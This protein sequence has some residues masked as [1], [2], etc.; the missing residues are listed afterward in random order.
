M[1]SLLR[2]AAAAAILGLV[3][4]GAGA[5]QDA[6]PPAV[7]VETLEPQTVTLTSVLPGRV[8]ASAEAEV[9]PQV[10]GIVT[11]RLFTEGGT[12][13][14]GDVLYRIDPVSYDAAVAQARAA[15]A[16]AEA[17]LRVAE[18]EAERVQTLSER[19]ISS[20]ANEE[21]A[22]STRDAAAAGLEAARAQLQ[23][24]EIELDRTEVRARLSG[25]IGFS[26]ASQGALVTASQATPL[27]IIRTL[28]PVYVDVTQSAADLLAWR[29]REGPA[30]EGH[31]EVSLELADGS[32]YDVTGR[33]N[34]AEPHVEEETGVVLLRMSFPNPD[35]LLLP[36]MY[37]QVEMPTGTA[38]DIFLVPQEGVSR[39]R[40]GN[41]TAMVANAENVVEE[42]P[43]TIL[44]DRGSDW[45]VSDGLEA[46]DRVIVA[47]L[48]KIA[49]GATVAPEE[50]DEEGSG[51]R[52]ADESAESAVQE[53]N[54][55]APDQRAGD[56]AAQAGGAAA[57]SQ[58]LAEAEAEPTDGE[59]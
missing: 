40:R 2:H 30:A 41:P 27:A 42:R 36:G 15:V 14:A 49:P 24:T 39:D 17:T 48:Q 11:E 58:D 8:R 19:G 23:T 52:G 37:V 56:E 33:L 46:G 25:R 7:T 54:A 29:R 21:S 20:S 10:S 32:T 55:S 45:I 5:A 59:R 43:L 35:G 44:Q 1:A 51:E 18:S 50:R 9:R 13:E 31:R 53:G 22:V 16:Q 57:A 38:E 4:A 26:E 28:D 6:P 12:V 3:R 34:A 47:G